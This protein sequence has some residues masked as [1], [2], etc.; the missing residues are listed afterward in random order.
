MKYTSQLFVFI[1]LINGGN[2]LFSSEYQKQFAAKPL[3]APSSF[4]RRSI[5]IPTT[6]RM[7]ADS[8]YC[9]KPPTKRSKS[10]SYLTRS[11]TLP[12]P[13]NQQVAKQTDKQGPRI[14]KSAIMNKHIAQL[15]N[16]QKAAQAETV[17][18][19]ALTAQVAL[20]ESHEQEENEAKLKVQNKK[21]ENDFEKNEATLKATN[22]QISR[23]N[24]KQAADLATKLLQ[25]DCNDKV[26]KQIFID[27][28]INFYNKQLP[29]NIGGD[30][31]IMSQYAQLFNADKNLDIR[32]EAA[33]SLLSQVIILNA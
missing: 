13:R 23:L 26:K 1:C 5:L 3:P 16:S 4:A 21:K 28:V 11:K 22:L 17:A 20:A 12:T 15:L 25:T 32:A 2:S 9:R 18:L 29:I 33:K 14:V 10:L 31:K 8:A 27:E 19:P 6:P 7:T 30:K 24:L